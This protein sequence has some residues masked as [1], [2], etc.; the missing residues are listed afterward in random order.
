MFTVVVQSS[1]RCTRHTA[2]VGVVNFGHLLRR[3][4]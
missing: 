3:L 2:N 1:N 4:I